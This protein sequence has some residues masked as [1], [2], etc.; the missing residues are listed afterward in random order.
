ML[1]VIDATRIVQRNHPEGIIKKVVSYKDLYL[2]MVF[3][4]RP[5]EEQMDPFFS[6]NKETGVFNEFSVLT[7]GDTSE[8]LSLFQ[9]ARER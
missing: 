1:N 4:N 5:F 7:D 3:N 2:F 6:V 8:V 9:N